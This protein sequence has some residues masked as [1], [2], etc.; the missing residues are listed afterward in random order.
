MNAYQS[1]MG[2]AALECGEGK[3]MNLNLAKEKTNDR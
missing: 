3:F 1:Q 2:T